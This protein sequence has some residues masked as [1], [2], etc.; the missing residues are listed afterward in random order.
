MESVVW[1]V[2]FEDILL[3]KHIKMV[4]THALQLPIIIGF[5]HNNLQR[6][7]CVLVEELKVHRNAYSHT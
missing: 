7:I 4:Q 2:K 1:L 3:Y 5:N 6:N